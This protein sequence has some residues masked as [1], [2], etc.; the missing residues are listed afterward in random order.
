MIREDLSGQMAFGWELHK[1][2]ECLVQMKSR[3]VL[4]EEQVR[5]VPEALLAHSGS[6]GVV[7]DAVVTARSNGCGHLL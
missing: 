3:G 4:L 5:E 7:T 2:K 6:T 1:A